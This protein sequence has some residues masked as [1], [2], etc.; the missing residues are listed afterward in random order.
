MT[1]LKIFQ[2]HQSPNRPA[3]TKFLQEINDSGSNSAVVISVK[4]CLRNYA[5]SLDFDHSSNSWISR[6]SASCESL[7]LI[8]FTAD[9]SVSA[10]FRIAKASSKKHPVL[11]ESDQTSSHA[12]H[13]LV[14]YD[15]HALNPDWILFRNETDE[16]LGK[17]ATEGI[18][19]AE[20]IRGPFPLTFVKDYMHLAQSKVFK[21][22]LT[23]STEFR[24]IKSVYEERDFG[25]GLI[26]YLHH[27]SNMS[28]V[29]L[30]DRHFPYQL[31]I[32]SDVSIL[33]QEKQTVMPNNEDF[34]AENIRIKRLY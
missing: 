33:D 10:D 34:A 31:K 1:L 25:T 8:T 3:L 27:L 17:L 20:T 32:E 21:P 28:R 29:I 16:L 23:E 7:L 12:L 24:E 9:S 19:I 11:E 13:V 30:R 18:E 2:A 26:E 14:A 22:Y 4:L 6:L 5:V 15:G